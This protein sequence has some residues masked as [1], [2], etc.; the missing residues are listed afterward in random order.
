MPRGM[1]RPCA[2]LML[3]SLV[4]VWPVMPSVAFIKTIVFVYAMTGLSNAKM[5]R[6]IRVLLLS[7]VACLVYVLLGYYAATWTLYIPCCV[8]AGFL[9]SSLLLVNRRRGLMAHRVL[10]LSLALIDGALLAIN[11]DWHFYYEAGT[12]SLSVRCHRT[13][14]AW[15]MPLCS[16]T[17]SST[18]PAQRSSVNSQQAWKATT[19]AGPKM[20]RTV[21]AA[22]RKAR[23]SY[24]YLP[25]PEV[26]KSGVV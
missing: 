21:G 23:V 9:C 26:T 7:S 14:F 1:T 2:L 6:A 8:F 16:P 24:Y 4:V 20:F 22:R 25:H 15:P 12:T 18:C 17:C 10:G 13:S 11:M 3:S 19:D 5:L